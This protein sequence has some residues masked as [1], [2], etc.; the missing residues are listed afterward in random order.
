MTKFNRHFQWKD[1]R[2]EKLSDGSYGRV[3]Y[4]YSGD[5]AVFVDLE[6]IINQ[7]GRTAIRNM[8]RTARVLNGLVVAK[9]SNVTK[10]RHA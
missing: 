1:T 6:K 4:E 7:Y 5:V 9:A 2:M 10:Q 3:T 8:S